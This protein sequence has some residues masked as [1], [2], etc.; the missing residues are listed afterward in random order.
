[1]SQT[2]RLLW[3]CTYKCRVT[4][5]PKKCAF[6][7]L[8]LF[9]C[10][11]ACAACNVKLRIWCSTRHTTLDRYILVFAVRTWAC[12]L[13]A[14]MWSHGTRIWNLINLWRVMDCKSISPSFGASRLDWL[15]T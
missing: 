3:Y 9:L 4:D 6:L 8:F 13:W 7:F 14:Y 11:A 5:L 1:M 12:A 2:T 10:V 15:D